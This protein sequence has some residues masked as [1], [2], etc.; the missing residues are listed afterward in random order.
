MVLGKFILSIIFYIID[1]QEDH[2]GEGEGMFQF[3]L[4][5]DTQVV[6]S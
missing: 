2:K 4:S 6:N 3:A 1:G 5:S